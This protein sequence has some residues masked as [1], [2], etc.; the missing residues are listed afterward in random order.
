MKDLVYFKKK[1]VFILIRIEAGVEDG[2]S[3]EVV[4]IF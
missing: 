2:G 1:G 4:A 3:V